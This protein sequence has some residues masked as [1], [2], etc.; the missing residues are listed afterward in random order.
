MITPMEN[1]SREEFEA[2][3]K[4]ILETHLKAAIEDFVRKNEERARELS[5]IERV[6]KVEEELRSLREIES[7]RFEASEKRFEALQREMNTRFEALQREMNARFEALQKE[8]NAR[9][10]AQQKETSAYFEAINTRFEAQQKETNARFEAINARFDAVE[11]RLNFM[12]WFMGAG[13]TVVSIL[14]ALFGFLKG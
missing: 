14:I 9:F 8:I 4:T 3:V 6:I 7:A 2:V 5:L 13:F 11:R 10:E 1:L 12:Q